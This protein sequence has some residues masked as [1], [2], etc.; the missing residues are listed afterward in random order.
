MST[1]I[2]NSLGQE[3][4]FEAAMSI[5]DPELCEEVHAM[6]L[7]TDQE[8]WDTYCKL[9]LQLVAYWLCVGFVMRLQVGFHT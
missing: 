9:H 3:I 4:D 6:S 7:D 5:A 2:V 8:Y 1:S